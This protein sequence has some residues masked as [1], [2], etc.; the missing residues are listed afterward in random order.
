MTA[1]I[2]GQLLGVLGWLFM[3]A[4]VMVLVWTLE[5]C[6][7]RMSARFLGP[8]TC[9]L[10]IGNVPTKL[11]LLRKLL[12]RATTTKGEEAHYHPVL[13]PEGKERFIEIESTAKEALMSKSPFTHL[14]FQGPRGAGKFSAAK[15]LAESLAIPYVLVCGASL[16]AGSSS[17]IDA[18][19]SWGNT[20]SRGKGIIVFIDEAE[21]FLAGGAREKVISKFAGVLDGARRDLFIILSTTR[22]VQELHPH[23]I[24]RCEEMKFNLPS[25]L[26]EQLR[27]GP[28]SESL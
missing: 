18:L 15:H 12:K 26:W 1:T 6:I 21:A 27:L 9:V 14:I 20:F 28:F 11:S 16:A 23:I 13:L 10:T 25:A 5:P 2:A 8:P 22:D 7:T 19:V 3:A 17:Q 4:S 24:E